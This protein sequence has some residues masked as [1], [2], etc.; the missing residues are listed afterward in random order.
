MKE[1]PVPASAAQQQKTVSSLK[2]R[3][4]FFSVCFYLFL[5]LAVAGFLGA[6]VS[7]IV[8]EFNRKMSDTLCYILLGGCLG[9]GA[10][11]GGAS[12]LFSRFLTDTD[13]VRLDFSERCDGENSFYVGEG[14]LATFERDSLLLHG[15][16][17][18]SKKIRVPYSEIRVFSVCT[19]RAPREK[20]EW[21]VVIEIPARYLAKGGKAEKDEKVLVQTDAKERLYRTVQVSGLTLLGEENKPK[22]AHKYA[23][24]AKFFVP[25]AEKRRRSLI[26]AVIGF[27]VAAAGIPVAIFWNATA[28]SFLSVI[29]FF[30][31]IR[32]VAAYIGAKSVF[33]AYEEGLYWKDANG[34]RIFLK[35][36]E[37]E[38][39]SR[40]EVNGAPLLK[41]QCIYGA[42][43]L[44]DISG[45]YEYLEG[46][47]P[48]KCGEKA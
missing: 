22:E 14:T 5:A 45:A 10:V 24:K 12:Y 2:R 40:T 29:G 19:R 25:V 34:E 31:G 20:G 27:A 46:F 30:M 7:V 32:S 21:S 28:G 47:R 1:I 35:W 3:S 41:V 18:N 42:Y 17:G 37:V 33:S 36:E 16:D 26:M 38:S 6:I 13:R 23:L 44:P 11:F 4:K 39:V 15:D 9:G 8:F 48:E 43:H